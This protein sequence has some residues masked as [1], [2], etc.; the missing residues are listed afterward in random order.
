MSRDYTNMVARLIDMVAPLMEPSQFAPHLGRPDQRDAIRRLIN[1]PVR[2]GLPVR[3]G[4][5]QPDYL[6][7]TREIVER[8][9]GTLP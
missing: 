7:I 1:E 3:L 9:S 5:L 4:V 8:S 2:L 6:A